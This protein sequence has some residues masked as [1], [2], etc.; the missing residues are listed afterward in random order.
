MDR[1][2]PGDVE[3]GNGPDGPEAG[4]G[5]EV[6]NG[7]EGPAGG[8]HRAGRPGSSGGRVCDPWRLGKVVPMR[9]KER[10]RAPRS[11]ELAE[12]HGRRRRDAGRARPGCGPPARRL[13]PAAVAGAAEASATAPHA[14]SFGSPTWQTGVI[15]DGSNPIALSSPNVANLPGG[16]AVVVGDEGG[17]CLH[18]PPGDRRRGMDV[19]GRR[20]GELESV[21]GRPHGGKQ[22]RHRL[23]RRG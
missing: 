19:Q 6:R 18:L 21:G 20:S 1:A 13:A 15:P 2:N 11:R 5:A 8:A 22:P 14:I 23:R 17:Q 16:P 4:I 7:S 12:R 3:T 10:G 9:S